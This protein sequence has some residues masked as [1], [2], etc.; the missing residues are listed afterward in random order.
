LNSWV[1]GLL[2]QFRLIN[3]IK[4]AYFFKK[5]ILNFKLIKSRSDL[6]DL[7]E[8]STSKKK[9]EKENMK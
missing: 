4:E 1:I 9:K 7:T 8:F 6:V 3:F 5:K 2:S